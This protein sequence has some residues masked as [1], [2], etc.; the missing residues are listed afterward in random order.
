MKRRAIHADMPNST[1][2]HPFKFHTLCN[3]AVRFGGREIPGE[4]PVTCKMCLKSLSLETYGVDLD[5]TRNQ[6]G[7][8]QAGQVG[9]AP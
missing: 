8:S 7:H 6:S 1:F 4:R 2:A 5:S 9:E 3:R